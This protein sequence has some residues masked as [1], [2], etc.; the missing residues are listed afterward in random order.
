LGC[1]F[2]ELANA[3]VAPHVIEHFLNSFFVKEF[4]E[5]DLDGINLFN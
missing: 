4:E 1:I 3:K 5:N 2:L